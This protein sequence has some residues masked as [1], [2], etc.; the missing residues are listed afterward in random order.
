MPALTY[1]PSKTET[2]GSVVTE[3]MASGLGGQRVPMRRQHQH[4]RD[5]FEVVVWRPV[6]LTAFLSAICS[7]WLNKWSGSG[8][9]CGP[10]TGT[11]GLPAWLGDQSFEHAT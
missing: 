8:R 3:A 1:F 11:P 4:I 10:C 9:M 6:V 7:G 5:R 2:F